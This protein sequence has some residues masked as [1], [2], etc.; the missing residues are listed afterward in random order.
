MRK[1][2]GRRLAVAAGIAPTSRSRVAVYG[3]TG[4]RKRSTWTMLRPSLLYARHDRVGHYTAAGSM[5]IGSERTCAAPRWP[6]P[7]NRQNIAFR[8]GHS[9]DIRRRRRLRAQIREADEHPWVHYNAAFLFFL[10]VLV[11]LWEATPPTLG[12]VLFVP[13]PI[14]WHPPP[15]P[16]FTRRSAEW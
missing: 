12:L 4:W 7:R 8:C 9:S 10:A 15:R 14:R 5:P 6:R 2:H 3:Y 16:P 13:R 1:W 11:A